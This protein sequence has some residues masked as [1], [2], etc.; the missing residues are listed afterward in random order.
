MFRIVSELW[1]TCKFV[2]S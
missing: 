2:F 1:Q